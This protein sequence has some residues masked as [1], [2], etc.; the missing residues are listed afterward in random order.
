MT[1]PVEQLSLEIY[2]PFMAVGTRAV[3][4]QW[5][6]RPMMAWPL[7]VALIATALTLT[8]ALSELQF[9]VRSVEGRI[10]LETAQMIIAALVAYLLWGRSGRTGL[11]RDFFVAAAFIIFSLTSLLFIWIRMGGALEEGSRIERVVIWAPLMARTGGTALLA[12]ASS[13]NPNRRVVHRNG[14][15]LF[16]ASISLVAAAT[17]AAFL[18]ADRL[19]QGLSEELL[20]DSSQVA[21]PSADVALQILQI[22]LVVLYGVAA[23]GFITRQRGALSDPLDITLAAGFTAAAFARLNFYLYPSIYSDVVHV[24]DFLRLFFFIILLVGATMEINRYWRVESESAAVIERQRLARELHDGLSQELSFI[25]SQ[26]AAM[27]KGTSYPGMVE[28]VARSAD[29]AVTESRALLLTVRGDEIVSAHDAL[30][31]EAKRAAG[32]RAAVEIDIPTGLL[33]PMKMSHELG[34]IVLEA[35]TNALR[36]GD[37]TRIG[38]NCSSENGSLK[39]V[40]ADD[41]TGFDTGDPKRGRHGIRGMRER[42]ELLGG[43]MRINSQQGSGTTVEVILPDPSV[44]AGY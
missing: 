10:A 11:L 16:L 15:H 1:L 19:P 34:R 42:V 14:V 36:H 2:T 9:A 44:R 25:S 26:T 28:L 39:L 8:V 3:A 30:A 17:L 12:A 40:I 4:A 6:V 27:A 33:L 23:V 35:T 24:G 37:A 18:L 20:L 7:A 29:R 43:T 38:V 41:G 21:G 13:I 22:L 32:S 5:R 31:A